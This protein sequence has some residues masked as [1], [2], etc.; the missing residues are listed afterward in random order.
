MKLSDAYTIEAGQLLIDDTAHIHRAGIL[1]KMETLLFLMADE[2]NALE[3]FGLVQDANPLKWKV[4]ALFDEFR[5]ESR[6]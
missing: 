6:K 5:A 3:Q 1:Q 2:V 4:Q